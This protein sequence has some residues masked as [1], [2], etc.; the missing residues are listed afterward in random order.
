MKADVA[1]VGAGPAGLAAA[2]AAKE[3]GAGH[4]I[5][6]DREEHLGGIL[7]Q[8]I[9]NGFGLHVFGEELTGREYAARFIEK[10][11]KRGITFLAETM[12]LDVSDQIGRASCRERV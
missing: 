6:L 2:I 7:R 11:Y 3:N 12:V 9:H 4:V 8:C 1:V 5:V 10:A